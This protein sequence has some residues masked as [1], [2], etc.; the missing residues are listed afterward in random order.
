MTDVPTEKL[1]IQ[2]KIGN[3]IHSITIRR[4]LEEIFRKAARNINEKLSRYQVSYP[5]MGYEKSM[6]ITLL[7]FAVYALQAE[8]DHSAEPYDAA[9][10]AL[11]K[12]VED[13]LT[14]VGD[15][16]LISEVRSKDKE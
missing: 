7:D 9:I 11:T 5:N 16:S 1:N 8:Q 14:E 15:A 2:L 3:Q 13:C 6:A 12:E 4:E 10:C